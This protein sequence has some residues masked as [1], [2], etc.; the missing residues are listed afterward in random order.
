MLTTVVTMLVN[1]LEPEQLKEFAD[2]GLDMLEDTIAKSETK[3]DDKVAVPI[4][5]A[6]RQAFA[7]ED[8][9]EVVE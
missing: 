7:I 3:L 4:I 1:R 8:N 9:D 6:I 5:N 2:M